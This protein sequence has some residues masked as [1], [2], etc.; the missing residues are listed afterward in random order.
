MVTIG[1]DA[2]KQV[3]AA[4]ALDDAGHALGHWRGPNSREGWTALQAWAVG[5]GAPR[6]WGIEGAWNYGRGLAQHLVDAGEVVYE[7]N[8]YR[9][10]QGRRSAGRPGKS[11]ALD[12]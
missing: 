11:D 7:V 3:H 10:A 4:V 2:H 1:V 12:A 5:L 9:T 8:P 6:R